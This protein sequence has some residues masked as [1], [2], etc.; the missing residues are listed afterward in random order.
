MIKGVVTLI[1][2]DGPPNAENILTMRINLSGS[3]YAAPRQQAEFYERALHDLQSIHGVDSVA[4]AT[5]VPFGDGGVTTTFGIE[6]R[7]LQPGDFRSAILQ[8]VSADNF[9][10]MKVPLLQGRYITESD[11]PETPAVALISDR[12]VQRHFFR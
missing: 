12:F 5:N 4:F 7:P 11:G 2:S 8:S 6:G 3:R 9:R 1:G 10:M